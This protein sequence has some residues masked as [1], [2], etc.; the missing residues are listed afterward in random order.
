MKR[1]YSWDRACSVD[2]KDLSNYPQ[3]DHDSWNNCPNCNEKPRLWIWD[4]GKQCKCRCQHVYDAP[5]ATGE[6]INEY[7]KKHQ[8]TEGYSNDDLRDKWNKRCELIQIEL[9]DKI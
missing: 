6:S 1:I 8:N 2:Y 5:Q 4:N 7:Y 9:K 3:E